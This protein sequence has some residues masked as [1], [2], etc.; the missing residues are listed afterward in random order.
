MRWLDLRHEPFPGQG[1][2]QLAAGYPRLHHRR[3]SAPVHHR[4]LPDVRSSAG[5]ARCTGALRPARLCQEYRRPR[6]GTNQGARLSSDKVADRS[7]GRDLQT[8]LCGGRRGLERT[9][10][11]SSAFH[12]GRRPAPLALE[13]A[14][15]HQ[16]AIGAIRHQACPNR[17]INVLF[18]MPSSD[19][20]QALPVFPPPERARQKRRLHLRLKI[21]LPPRFGSGAVLFSKTASNPKSSADLIFTITN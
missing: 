13:L 12:S 19:R 20:W 6:N 16:T 18:Q 8:L 2:T 14:R 4:R 1:T 21:L 10:A 9:V 17:N 11:I 5:T 3:L 7:L 15:R